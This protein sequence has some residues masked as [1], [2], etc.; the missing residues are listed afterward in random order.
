[1]QKVNVRARQPRWMR[2]RESFNAHARHIPAR[3]GRAFRLAQPHGR[4]PRKR[5]QPAPEIIRMRLDDGRWISRQRVR[6]HRRHEN[7]LRHRICRWHLAERPRAQRRPL[8]RLQK[9]LAHLRCVQLRQRCVVMAR[10]RQRFF[11]LWRAVHVNHHRLQHAPLAPVDRADHARSRRRHVHAGPRFIGKQRLA[12]LHPIAH[13]NGHRRL[14][15]VIV[16]ADDSH[17]A[18]GLRIA[19]LRLGASRNGEVQAALDLDHLACLTSW[20]KRV[21]FYET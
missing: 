9:V 1:M 17:A 2:P 16:R 20:D 5:Q 10:E 15:A 21:A 13:L 3:Q 11:L 7:G 6:V 18:H 8:A 12:R 14:E 19:D 4:Q